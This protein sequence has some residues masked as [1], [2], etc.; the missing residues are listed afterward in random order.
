MNLLLSKTGTWLLYIGI[1][2]GLILVIGLVLYFAFGL[3]KKREKKDII[4]IDNEY[5]DKILLSLG[6]KDNI[7]ELTSDNGRVKFLINNLELLDTDSLKELSPRGVFI[8]GMNVKLLF[9]YE[10][11]E[12]INSLHQRGVK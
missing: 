1:V 4:T 12:V 5:I 2:L 6:G 7:L 10:A 3:R 11:N 8:T 9:K